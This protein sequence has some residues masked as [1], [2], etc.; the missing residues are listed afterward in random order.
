[1]SGMMSKKL[2][3]QAFS[4]IHP[5]DEAIERIMN[6]TEKRSKNYKKVLAVCF[7]TVLILCSLAIGANAVTDGGVLQ[8]VEDIVETVSNRI[9]VLV[10][11]K[12]TYAKIS[13]TEKIGKDGEKHWEGV[14][15]V[16]DDGDVISVEGAFPEEGSTL[17]FGSIE[18]MLEE[19]LKQ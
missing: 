1:M 10:N 16:G 15:V 12:E 9:T 5:S 17:D 4:D 2:Y 11:G 13:V 3:K 18:I 19:S 6:M 14:V 7:V 8:T